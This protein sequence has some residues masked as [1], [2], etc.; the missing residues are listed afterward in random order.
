MLHLTISVTR[1]AP[2]TS[3]GR[4]QP[5]TE[6]FSTSAR[7]ATFGEVLRLLQEAVRSLA[8]W[9]EAKSTG[10]DAIAREQVLAEVVPMLSRLRDPV[11]AA[12][13]AQQLSIPEEEIKKRLRALE[14]V[15]P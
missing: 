11:L 3:E 13:V 2:P 8:V 14:V 10:E 1:E 6:V 15:A 4:Y 5:N 12:R 9:A 7:V